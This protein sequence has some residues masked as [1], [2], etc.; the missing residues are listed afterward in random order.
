M[1]GFIV[2]KKEST[3]ICA[4]CRKCMNAMKNYTYHLVAVLTVGIWGLTFIST[5][6][7]IGHGLSP[8]E[9]F[10]LR[11]LIAYMGIWLISP[12]KLFAD[13]WKDEFWMFLGGM[14]GG[15]FYFFTENTALE[16]TLAT[17][18]SF[19]VCTAPLLTTILSLWVYKKEKA[20]R[21]LMA[22]SL[23]ALVGV[24]LVVYNGSFVLKI[25][26]LGD[27]LTLLA[28]F[29]WAFYSLIMRKMSNRYGITFITRKIFFYG[30]LTILP[31]FLVHPWQFDIARL[32]EPAILFNLLFLGVL[33]SLICFV[34]WNVVLKQLGT[35]RASNY[36]YLNPLFT[37]VGSA[38]LAI[39]MFVLFTLLSY[40]LFEPVRKMLDERKRRVKEEQDTAKKERADAVVFKEEYETKLKEVDKEAQV[41]LSEARKKAMKTE[42]Q[43]VAEAKEEAARIIARANAEVELE[44]KRALDEMKQEMVAIA[45]LMAG[46]VVKASIDTNVQESLIDETLKE[47]GERTWLS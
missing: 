9:I 19:I 15:S 46:K 8:Q 28:A 45:S 2:L 47:M 10:L 11:F 42:S 26:P 18:V 34:V 36:I 25:S 43:I 35:I 39:A 30:V 1:V 14:T 29:S 41:I 6:V 32:L 7:L 31:A 20:T 3:Y 22:G 38:F 44:K 4:T 16:I 24:A 5:K 21:G 33:A 12:R 27:F 37:L 13:N 23:L 17:N 40:L